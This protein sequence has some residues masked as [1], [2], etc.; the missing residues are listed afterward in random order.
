[1]GV[2]GPPW[3]EKRPDG[4]I[5]QGGDRTASVVPPRLP[6][7]DVS[8]DDAFIVRYATDSQRGLSFHRDGC[9]AELLTAII[10]EITSE[11]PISVAYIPANFSV[12]NL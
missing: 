2:P 4:T 12:K 1:M 9:L 11:D 10:G 6:K 7:E 3:L 8:V 5:D